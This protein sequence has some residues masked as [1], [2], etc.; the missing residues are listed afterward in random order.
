MV[1]DSCHVSQ[2]DNQ[3]F[4]SASIVK[5]IFEKYKK[6]GPI[7]DVRPSTR[8]RSGRTADN[9]MPVCRM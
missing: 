2:I 9:I 6:T 1:T 3:K 5:R 8:I 4:P 7:T